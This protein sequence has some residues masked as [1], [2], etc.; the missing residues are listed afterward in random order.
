MKQVFRSFVTLF[1]LY[2]QLSSAVV[3]DQTKF[4]QDVH[5]LG[6]KD[7]VAIRF[8]PDGQVFLAEKEGRVLQY[9][10]VNENVEAYNVVVDLRSIT[11]NWWDRGMLG[12]AVHPDYPATPLVFALFSV[13]RGTD[14]NGPDVNLWE[15]TS[16]PAEEDNYCSSAARLIRIRV[17][18]ATKQGNVEQVLLSD[19]CSGSGS[20]HAGDLVWAP[21]NGLYISAGD[22]SAFDFADIGLQTDFCYRPD[23]PRLQGSFRS[24]HDD[25]LHGKILHVPPESL[26]V[27]RQLVLNTDF[28]IVAKG[29]RN[30]FR[31]AVHPLTNDL[32]VGD[33][34][35]EF[36]EEIDVVPNPLDPANQAGPIPNYGWPCF[37]GSVAQPYFVAGNYEICNN[38]AQTEQWNVPFFEYDRENALPTSDPEHCDA[39]N[40]SPTG[41]HF[42]TGTLFDEEFQGLL[43]WA[44]GSKRC[45]FYFRNDAHD[46]PNPNQ[47]ET[48]VWTPAVQDVQTGQMI[49]PGQWVDMQVDQDGFLYMVDF[50]AS[51]VHRISSQGA[52]TDPY[53]V[54]QVT[55]DRSLTAPLL[56]TLDATGSY[57]LDDGDE[58]VEFAWDFD[59]D[60]IDDL[61]GDRNEA[62]R[63]ERIFDYGVYEV[64]LRVTDRSDRSRSTSVLISAG[65]TID[66]DVNIS[67]ATNEWTVNDRLYFSTTAVTDQNEIVP[68]ELVSWQAVIHHCTRSLCGGRLDCHIHPVALEEESQTGYSGSFRPFSH[69]LPSFWN[70]T[71]TAAHPQ[72]PALRISKQVTTHSRFYQITLESQPRGLPMELCSHTPC[73]KDTMAGAT[74][75]PFVQG[76][77]TD[78]RSQLY[79]FS[80]WDVEGQPTA[81]QY[82]YRPIGDQKLVAVFNEVS[83][84]S[85]DFEGISAPTGVNVVSDFGELR[86]SW[87]APVEGASSVE[88][89]VVQ[90]RRR[91]ASPDTPDALHIVSGGQ[92]NAVIQVPV[93][94]E[95]YQVAV[96]GVDASLRRGLPSLLREVRT[97]DSPS[98]AS[99]KC[100]RCYEDEEMLADF[101][102]AD[103]FAMRLSSLRTV[104]G[105]DH[106]MDLVERRSRLGDYALHLIPAATSYFYLR[107]DSPGICYDFMP[108]GLRWTSIEFTVV[109]PADGSFEVV[110]QGNRQGC[111]GESY[112][113]AQ[114]RVQDYLVSSNRLTGQKQRVVI[115]I[116]DLTLTG[117]STIQ[118][119]HFQPTQ[120]S[121][122]IDSLR[123]VR[124]CTLHEMKPLLDIAQCTL[125]VD[126]FDDP[127][128]FALDQNKVPSVETGSLNTM[129][130]RDMNQFQLVPGGHLSLIPDE[131]G[132]FWTHLGR[133]GY[134]FDLREHHFHLLQM[135]VRTES[136]G[137]NFD[138]RLVQMAG[139]CGSRDDSS[140]LLVPANHWGA[141][142]NPNG[143]STLTI[144]LSAFRASSLSRIESIELVNFAPVGEQYLIDNIRLVQPCAQVPLRF[145]PTSCS[146]LVD[147]FSSSFEEANPLGGRRDV[148]AVTATLMNDGGVL[149]TNPIDSH[150]IITY[151][152]N[153]GLKICV[154]LSFYDSVEIE[155]K[156]SGGVGESTLH[157]Q[158]R[159]SD[160]GGTDDSIKQYA[161]KLKDAFIQQGSQ[162]H[163]IVR[164]P[165]SR[166]SSLSMNNIHA[167]AISNLPSQGMEVYSINF[168]R[169]N[170]CQS[171]EVNEFRGTC[172]K[173]VVNDFNNDS[174]PIETN[175]LGQPNVDDGT[176]QSLSR[177]DDGRAR[178]VPQSKSSYWINL[179]PGCMDLS[180]YTHLHMWI[181][182]E[183]LAESSRSSLNLQVS[184]QRGTTC[185]ADVIEETSLGSVID[186]LDGPIDALTGARSVYFPME[187]ANKAQVSGIVL[188][189]FEDTLTGQAPEAVI[190][191]NIYFVAGDCIPQPEEGPN[192]WLMIG[193]IVLGTL[194]LLF[195]LRRGMKWYKERQTKK[196]ATQKFVAASRAEPAQ[197]SVD[198]IPSAPSSLNI[199][200]SN[201]HFSPPSMAPRRGSHQFDS[202]RDSA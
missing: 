18:Q 61:V 158:Q 137:F 31:F 102:D 82:R 54:L 23:D 1:L 166:F 110:L 6:T 2:L 107:L 169:S 182:P 37:E 88:F 175:Q 63:F 183:A 77:V 27:N 69:P 176:L 38:L 145:A 13:N 120:R 62:S 191:D 7:A 17:D 193:L 57:D 28:R 194:V 140:Q 50:F 174:L 138:V 124:N 133:P 92:L 10:N 65:V 106:T 142:Q 99:T 117:M 33:V 181:A 48:L 49:N 127:S 159:S 101:E 136:L 141:F 153:E 197:K 43:F 111:K 15:K 132:R 94:V 113:Y 89:Y 21:D 73:S 80:H 16:C 202:A 147:N 143:W 76:L 60:G 4:R 154:D 96:S 34:G 95:W 112:D 32:Y 64:Q 90:Y 67:P 139:D 150:Q 3:V 98:S 135:D 75:E 41:L 144:P 129:D 186:V 173:L 103:D 128:R 162:G 108:S 200:E 164:V 179:L 78:A 12:L 146:L 115:P 177:T 167:L 196:M 163:L 58:I 131:N 51:S 5:W 35:S 100:L 9:D 86:A 42:Y 66:F 70:L 168:V 68:P 130:D 109:G 14:V 121:F 93:D 180:D 56:T 81:L 52:E 171:F 45:A 184:V 126:D 83:F 72:Y 192:L 53:P 188:T 123:L 25:Y 178:L 189:A 79:R 44:D 160:C 116:W 199:E 155:L 190:L 161:V 8:A 24:Q 134:C 151:L 11:Y 114:F 149:L 122:F 195:A 74:I 185:G 105:D 26:D 59:G 201:L 198:V 104:I 148:V 47:M 22:G 55:Q 84:S 40:A 152:F 87:K 157:L 19:W 172:D 30:P 20:H 91:D 118:F 97:T 71:V 85:T 29:F 125:V 187:G 119:R 165:T 170:D 39:I 46:H 156:A 36:F